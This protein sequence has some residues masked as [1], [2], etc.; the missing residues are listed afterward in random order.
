MDLLGLFTQNPMSCNHVLIVLVLT[1]SFFM[2]ATKNNARATN[3]IIDKISSSVEDSISGMNRLSLD[4]I[5]WMANSANAI[6]TYR[7]LFVFRD[8]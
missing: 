5:T 7:N 4:T 6:D 3:S 1:L 2:I 8:L